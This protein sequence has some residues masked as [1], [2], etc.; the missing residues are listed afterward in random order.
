MMISQYGNTGCGVFNNT[1]LEG[2][3]NSSKPVITEKIFVDWPI[4]SLLSHQKVNMKKKLTAYILVFCS[5]LP[6]DEN[7]RWTGHYLQIYG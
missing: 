1:I 4:R 2:F 5:Y 7:M 6:K 3:F